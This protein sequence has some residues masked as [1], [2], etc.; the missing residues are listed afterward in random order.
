MEET[1]NDSELKNNFLH[2]CGGSTLKKKLGVL[3]S[4]SGFGGK[5]EMATSENHL[6]SFVVIETFTRMFQ[7][8]L[9]I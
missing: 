2:V 8:F 5:L 4:S 1:L 3:D 9:Y 6:V 7:M